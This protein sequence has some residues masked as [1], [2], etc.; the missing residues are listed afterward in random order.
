[1]LAD[2][3]G[4]GEYYDVRKAAAIKL[5]GPVDQWTDP[6]LLADVAGNDE[7]KEVRRAAIENLIGRECFMEALDGIYS[8]NNCDTEDQ[9]RLA[10]VLVHVAQKSGSPLKMPWENIKNWVK[11]VPDIPHHDRSHSD[12]YYGG[13]WVDGYLYDEKHTDTPHINIS[14]KYVPSFPPYPIL[15]T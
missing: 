8:F 11:Q 9:I 5:T 12:Y 2:F 4:N 7:S 6:A 1:V 15:E 13:Q 14:A 3:A 10:T